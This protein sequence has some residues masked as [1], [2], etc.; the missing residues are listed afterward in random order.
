MNVAIVLV[1]YHTPELAVRAH[2]AL[3]ADLATSQLE[4][5]WLLVD[6]GSDER[7]KEILR[8]L[9]VR[10]LEPGKNLGY[11]GGANLGVRESTADFIFVMN[12]DVE[13]LPGCAAALCEALSAGAAVA[14][15]RFYWDA[16]RC[17]QLP[18]TEK[19]NRYDELLRALAHRGPGM[20]RRARQRWRRHAWRLWTCA[21]TTPCFELSG[22]ML[23]FQRQAWEEL[24]GFD[25]GY[26]LYFEETDFLER[27]RRQKRRAAF[28]P[29][30]F[31]P[32]A[33][34]VHLYAQSTLAEPRANDW[35][36]QSQ[37]RFFHRFYG[38]G[39]TRFL[40][41]LSRRSSNWPEKLPTSTDAEAHWLEVAASPLGF[42]AAGRNVAGLPKSQVFEL[43][44]SLRARMPAGTYY[45]RLLDK[46][47]RELAQRSLAVS[48]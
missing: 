18:P 36:A 44:G 32:A 12:P 13:V 39:F 3:A 25:E 2:E 4:A 9:P 17:F 27:L 6:N 15:P 8:S 11:A 23:A 16:D 42:P 20:A 45:L 37:R 38:A 26:P 35:F 30:A 46:S 34:A 14:G 7:E 40:E 48:S 21:E 33:E 29:A 5:E 41:R 1:H 47:G 22:A 24:E 10:L 19:R 31:V 28:F 43:A